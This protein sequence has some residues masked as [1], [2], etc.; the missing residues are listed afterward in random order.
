M[1]QQPNI[2]YRKYSMEDYIWRRNKN[3][4]AMGK[5]IFLLVKEILLVKEN[6]KE[7]Q[8]IQHN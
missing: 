5:N 4:L 8:Y 6:Y 2:E 3:R 1:G 7:T